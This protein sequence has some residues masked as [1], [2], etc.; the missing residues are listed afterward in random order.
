MRYAKITYTVL[1]LLFFF[2][3]NQS[4]A[5]EEAVDTLKA[6]IEETVIP[7]SFLYNKAVLQRYEEYRKK[8]ADILALTKQVQD[9]IDNETTAE[10]SPE[11][12]R[13][14]ALSHAAKREFEALDKQLNDDE[15]Q[16]RSFGMLQSFSTDLVSI[17]DY[18]EEVTKTRINR[19]LQTQM[20][21]DI[22]TWGNY[23]RKVLEDI[24]LLDTWQAT[25]AIITADPDR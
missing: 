1:V 3:I 4:L 15:R 7:K 13:L 5:E 17:A 22:Q 10:E 12:Q 23:R 6:G 25:E 11:L 19:P 21:R 9:Y 8:L 2:Q 20:N 14:S 18:W 16:Y 24:K